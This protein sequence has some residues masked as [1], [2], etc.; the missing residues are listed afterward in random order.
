MADHNDFLKIKREVGIWD[1]LT[2]ERERI[3]VAHRVVGLVALNHI[4]NN[5][6]R[7]GLRHAQARNSAVYPA[8]LQKGLG[9]VLESY[10]KNAGADFHGV[11]AES[12]TV[13]LRHP[14][15]NQA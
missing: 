15:K 4:E 9:E 1:I 8:D 3:Y 14:Y 7:R 2:P 11:M 6:L 13:F 12:S 10:I 5:D